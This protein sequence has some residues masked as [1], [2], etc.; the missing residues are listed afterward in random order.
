[1]ALLYFFDWRYRSASVI[2]LSLDFHQ[3]TGG[4]Y[5]YRNETFSNYLT[6]HSDSIGPPRLHTYLE[7]SISEDHCVPRVSNSRYNSFNGFICFSLRLISAFSFKCN[8]Y[9][10]VVILI[11]IIYSP[12]NTSSNAFYWE[13]VL[14]CSCGFC[15]QLWS[16]LGPIRRSLAN[17]STQGM[18]LVRYHPEEGLHLSKFI[19]FWNGG[20]L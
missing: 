10:G 12:W 7:L 9:F 18:G 1:M 11:L 16:S 6:T 4:S 14:Y 5:Y 2:V 20:K 8:D 13:S 15:N 3:H 17:F 19:S